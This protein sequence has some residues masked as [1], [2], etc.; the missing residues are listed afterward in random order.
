MAPY[1]PFF[2]ALFREGKSTTE[3]DLGM[4]LDQFKKVDKKRFHEG[5]RL[6][7]IY[8]GFGS[9]QAAWHE[10]SKPQS[11]LI[12]ED[13]DELK[14]HEKK[15]EKAGFR[16]QYLNTQGDLFIAIW[17]PGSGNQFWDVNISFNELKSKD[18]EFRSKGLM[19]MNLNN[20]GGN[21]TAFWQPG[22]RKYDW[23]VTDK[24]D[25]F[26]AFKEKNEKKGLLGVSYGGAEFCAV[27]HEEKGDQRFTGALKEKDFKKRSEELFKENF[28]IVDMHLTFGTP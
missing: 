23:I 14:S 28:H 11:W 18:E 20:Y 7:F 27:F 16:L 12:T 19:L 4:D 21:Y 25:Q 8:Y 26:V 10:S 15:N 13:F 3:I 9:Y 2:N 17:H 5:N 1:V 24:E 22:T 6:T